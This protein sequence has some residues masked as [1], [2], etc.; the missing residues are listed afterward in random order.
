[1]LLMSLRT[2][3]ELDLPWEMKDAAHF[4]WYSGLPWVEFTGAIASWG[5]WPL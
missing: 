1:M 4:P 5:V 3:T 2:P